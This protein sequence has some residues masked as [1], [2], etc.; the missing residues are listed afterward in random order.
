MFSLDS[1]IL[2]YSLGKLILSHELRV[3]IVGVYVPE[4]LTG[5]L[6]LGDDSYFE[7][8]VYSNILS[9]TYYLKFNISDETFRLCY[10]YILSV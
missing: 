7:I 2:F 4:F 3:N 6:I 9:Y 8:T 1:I 10:C 5:V